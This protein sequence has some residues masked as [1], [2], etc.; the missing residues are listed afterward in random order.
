MEK[1]D[2]KYKIDNYEFHSRASAIIYNADK[3][4]VLLFKVDDGRDFYLLPGGRIQINEDSLSAI[5]REIKEEIGY[6]LDYKIS[7]VNENF[8]VKNKK[9]IMQYEFLYKAVYKGKIEKLDFECLDRA[10][11][12]FHWI[13]LNELDNIKILPENI[14][15]VIKKV[16]YNQIH[17]ILKGAI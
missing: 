11:Q 16:D 7:S 6:D 8:L 4:K 9:N 3:T 12:S 13:E 10:G 1:K 17:N 2:L 14:K 5:K 15:K